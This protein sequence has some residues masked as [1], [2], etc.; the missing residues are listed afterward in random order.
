MTSDLHI[1]QAGNL[2]TSKF[3]HGFLTRKGGVSSGIYATLNTSL[4]SGDD[5]INIQKNWEIIARHYNMDVASFKYI[6]QVHGNRAYEVIDRNENT[7]SV[8]ADALVTKLKAVVLCIRTA[9]CCPIILQDKINGVIAVIHAGW[10]SAI[11]GIIQNT[12]AHMLS[13]GA[14]L[15][16]IS[17]AIGPTIAQANYEVDSMFYQQFI[18]QSHINKKYFIE[19]TST[20]KYQF[21]LPGYCEDV[22]IAHHI[23]SVENLHID[24][25]S[26]EAEFHSCRRAFHRNEAGFGDQVSLIM[27]HKD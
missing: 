9:D 16:S 15:E 13:I 19:G 21:D 6:H 24:T 14:K 18:T 4:R 8:E 22:L 20:D 27:M 10:R 12:I 3:T 2:L 1:K 26:N 7:A 25:Y 17:A 23:K 11:S 5:R